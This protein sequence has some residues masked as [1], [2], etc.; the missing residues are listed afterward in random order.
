MPPRSRSRSPVAAAER[1]IFY[2]PGTKEIYVNLRAP[3]RPQT[4][5]VDVKRDDKLILVKAKLHAL[6]E[7]PWPKMDIWRVNRRA[8]TRGGDLFELLHD[9]DKTLGDERIWRGAVLEYGAFVDR[10]SGP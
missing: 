10:R 6:L 2:G 1:G 8:A 4:I 5:R 7:L 3:F 9:D